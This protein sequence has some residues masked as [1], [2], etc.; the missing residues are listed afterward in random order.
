[1]KMKYE[2]KLILLCDKF[3]PNEIKRRKEVIEK[4]IKAVCIGK[5]NI[6]NITGKKNEDY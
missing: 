4:Y 6:E 1:M 2:K 5:I 3:A